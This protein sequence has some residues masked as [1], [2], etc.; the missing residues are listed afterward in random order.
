MKVHQSI[1]MLMKEMYAKYVEQDIPG[2]SQYIGL[3]LDYGTHEDHFQV[4]IM[5]G[6]SVA[7]EGL[8]GPIEPEFLAES[9]GSG[10]G[11]PHTLLSKN[12]IT[13]DTAGSEGISVT[14]N[15]GVYESCR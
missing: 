2:D 13:V 3:E 9:D 7:G 15:S 14:Q 1:L 5:S 8:I 10:T 11:A 4:E 12:A 6:G